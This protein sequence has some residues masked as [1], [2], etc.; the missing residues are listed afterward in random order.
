ML[1][2]HPLI[3]IIILGVVVISM[4]DGTFWEIASFS[5]LAVATL[6]AICKY[7]RSLCPYL[8]HFWQFKLEISSDLYSGDYNTQHLPSNDDIYNSSQTLSVVG[9][10]TITF[11]LRLKTKQKKVDF[12]LRYLGIDGKD[13]PE[14]VIKLVKPYGFQADLRY[15]DV[16]GNTDYESGLTGMITRPSKR[17]F[18]KYCYMRVTV[19]IK[20]SCCGI[21][22]FE[23]RYRLEDGRSLSAKCQARLNIQVTPSIPDKEG[24]QN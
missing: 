5:I 9:N 1:K 12:R 7:G 17:D 16:T 11:L 4:P 23:G 3:W 22:K 24:S 15:W 10:S 14:D 2:N 13:F 18:E 21:L 19:E 20:Q 8:C 6:I